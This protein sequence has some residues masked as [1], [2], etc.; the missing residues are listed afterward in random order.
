MSLRRLRWVTIIVAI[1]FLVCVQGLAMGY[2]MPTFGRPLGHAVSI[3]GFSVGIIVLAMFLYRKIES[4][5]ARIVRQN[6]E[7]EALYEIAVDISA[8]DDDRQVLRSIVDRARE[9]LHAD[10]VVLRLD[11][12]GAPAIVAHAGL[13][14]ASRHHLAAAAESSNEPVLTSDNGHS[15]FSSTRRGGAS[16]DL[17]A[18]GERIGEIWVSPAGGHSLSDEELRLLQAMADLAAIEV[19]KGRLMERDRLVAVLE[20][21]ERLARE[22]H[23]SL[24]QV[25]GYLHL[26]SQ[27]AQASLSSGNTDRVREDLAEI[28]SVSHEAYADVREAILGLRETVSPHRGFV[29]ALREYLVKFSHQAG[30]PTKVEIVG[31]REPNLSPE[32]EVQ[33]M[34]VIQEAL[35]NVRK[36]S[37]ARKACVG[38]DQREGLRITIEDDGKGFNPAD[39]DENS[40]HFGLYTMRERVERVGGRLVIDSVAGQGTRVCVIFS[41]SEAGQ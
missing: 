25:L 41:G 4:M 21:R 10:A 39:L 24:A 36:H 29:D 16:A 12:N 13:P 20:E 22:M 40:D 15:S 14:E 27:G 3:T 35:T 23:D 32:A 5:Q 30:V 34:R 9:M 28:T 19:Q 1:G 26:K 38:L 37:G 7:S 11:G 18:G 17:M 33:L 2:V 6:E 31:D 8:L